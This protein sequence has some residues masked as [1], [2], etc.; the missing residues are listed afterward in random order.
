MTDLISTLPTPAA[1]ARENARRPV[2]LGAVTL[3]PGMLGDWQRLNRTATIPHCLDRLESTGVL[4][5][6]RRLV[7]ESDAPFRGP[8]FADS[9]LYKTLEAI[10]WE[11]VTGDVTEHLPSGC[12]PG[13]RSRTGT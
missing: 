11:A 2:P 1:P 13:R 10:G 8:L 4:D 3:G 7:G 6:L 5:N 12:S 9:D